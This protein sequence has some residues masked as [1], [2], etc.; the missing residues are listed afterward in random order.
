MISKRSCYLICQI[1]K[2]K[3]LQTSNEKNRHFK[4]LTN[5]ARDIVTNDSREK[6]LSFGWKSRSLQFWLTVISFHC[7]F[8]VDFR[9]QSTFVRRRRA[10]SSVKNVTDNGHVA[11]CVVV[12]VLYIKWTTLIYLVLRL[13]LCS[14]AMFVRQIWS[15]PGKWLW[16]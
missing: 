5:H 9:F 2:K 15:T 7:L 11:G 16:L 4:L 6:H 8:Y 1:C 13:K 12:R 10:F 14:I 3:Q